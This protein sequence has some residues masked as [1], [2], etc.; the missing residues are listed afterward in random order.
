MG[1]QTHLG[2][3]DECIEV[4]NVQ[5]KNS[6]FD[7][8]YC[9]VTISL[10]E[11][12]SVNMGSLSDLESQEDITQIK[13]VRVRTTR[14]LSAQ[15]SLLNLQLSYCIPS[16]CSIK[17][18]ENFLVKYISDLQIDINFNITIPDGMCQTTHGRTLGAD[19]WIAVA[20]LII[21]I[22]LTVSSTAYDL[23]KK[24]SKKKLLTAFSLFSNGKKLLST[25][26]SED[27]IQAIQGMRLISMCWVIMGHRYSLAMESPAINQIFV[28]D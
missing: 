14:E 10:S 23:I 17:D 12:D 1:L 6:T 7:A 25:K 21:I 3:F 22:L 26:T 20:I 11:L 27:T 24:E 8:Q 28:Q 15:T 2:N 18:F 5:T 13:N 19:D 4:Q 16:T 9:L